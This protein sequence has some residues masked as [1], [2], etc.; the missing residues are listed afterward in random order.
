MTAKLP[1]KRKPA[2]RKPAKKKP[3]AAVV[4]KSGSWMPWFSLF[5]NGLLMLGVGAVGGWWVSGGIEIGRWRDD[6]LSQAYDADRATQVEVLREL[7]AQPFD[8]ATDDGRKQAGE[9]F[10][11]QRFR[12]RPD[13][14]GGY[15][16]AVAEAIAANA[17][18]EL[19]AKLEGK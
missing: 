3:V 13:D 1:V 17:E 6:V 7:A 15:T 11:A 16:D 2:K 10:N 12:N 14:F 18:A 19:A 9:F 5:L 4:T 8:G